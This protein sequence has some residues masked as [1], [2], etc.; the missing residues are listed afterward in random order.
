MLAE[1]MG[2]KYLSIVNGD[3]RIATVDL[4]QDTPYISVSSVLRL[5]DFKEIVSV[6]EETIS[7]G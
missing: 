5:R 2:E 7:K 6:I 3:Q 4:S 1:K